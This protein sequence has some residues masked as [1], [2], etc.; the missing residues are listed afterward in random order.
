MAEQDDARQGEQIGAGGLLARHDE[1]MRAGEQGLG[2][3]DRHSLYVQLAGVDRTAEMLRNVAASTAW[4]NTLA[5]LAHPLAATAHGAA[6]LADVVSAAIV[7]P[8]PAVIRRRGEPQPAAQPPR[9]ALLIPAPSPAVQQ[10]K[11][12]LAHLSPREALELLPAL[13]DLVHGGEQRL[14]YAGRPALQAEALAVYEH[15][16]AH[17]HSH[18]DK[19]CAAL[20]GLPFNTWRARRAAGRV[21]FAAKIAQTGHKSGHLP[22]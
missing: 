15:W 10:I 5:D 20:S 4:L 6:R 11:R 2:A 17:R 8:A 16:L 9:P 12:Q 1:L 13:A 18:S 14:P 22:A 21:L 7:R 3:L 19:G